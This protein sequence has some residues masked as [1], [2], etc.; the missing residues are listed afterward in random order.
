MKL[1][2]VRLMY[3]AVEQMDNEANVGPSHYKVYETSDQ[4]AVPNG[5]ME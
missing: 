3:V 4:A 1:W 2:L 5:I